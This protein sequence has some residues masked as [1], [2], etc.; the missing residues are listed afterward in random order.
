MRSKRTVL[1]NLA[2]KSRRRREAWWRAWSVEEKRRIQ[3][4]DSQFEMI[5]F[6]VIRLEARA[7]MFLRY[8]SQ[9]SFT[10][11]ETTLTSS[12]QTWGLSLMAPTDITTLYVLKLLILRID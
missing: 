12:I 2:N 5:G 7:A 10:R 8:L 4:Q 1:K 9:E 6:E 3:V 11:L